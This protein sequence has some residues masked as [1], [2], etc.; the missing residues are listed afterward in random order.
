MKED[1]VWWIT[2]ASA[3]LRHTCNGTKCVKH[4]RKNHRVVAAALELSGKKYHP[5]PDGSSIPAVTAIVKEATGMDINR[6]VAAR[7]VASME[8]GSRV[9]RF[10][11]SVGSV[12]EVP[13]VAEVGP[14]AAL[15]NALPSVPGAYGPPL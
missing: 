9:D 7:M 1:G 6:G 15:P 4:G 13:V 11:A 2:A 8:T 12:G 14:L 10:P 3:S 5:A